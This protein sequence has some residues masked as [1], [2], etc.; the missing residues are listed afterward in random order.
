L[1]THDLTD[2]EQRDDHVEVH[3]GLSDVQLT[4]EIVGDQADAVDIGQPGVAGT[5]LV[6]V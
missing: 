2:A 4:N 6:E 3:R 1:V 5:G